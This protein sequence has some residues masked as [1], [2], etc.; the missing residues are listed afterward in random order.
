MTLTKLVI[1]YHGT[2]EEPAYAIA[3]NH[4][5]ETESR[6]VYVFKAVNPSLVSC[7]VS[8]KCKGNADGSS[9]NRLFIQ[10]SMQF[11]ITKVKGRCDGCDLTF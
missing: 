1:P 6:Y 3:I 2:H 8:G 5:Y 11:Y 9:R 7:F 4:Q 10:F